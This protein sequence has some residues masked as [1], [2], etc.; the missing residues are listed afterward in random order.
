MQHFK[1]IEACIVSLRALHARDDIGPKQKKN[2][3]A[4]IE[5]AKQLR[6]RRVADHAV[7]CRCVRRITESLLRAFLND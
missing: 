3:E 6:R 1:D 5:E 7:A 2:V 4:A